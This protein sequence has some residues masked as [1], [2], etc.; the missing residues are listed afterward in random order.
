MNKKLSLTLI[1]LTSI[2]AIFSPIVV[3][4]FANATFDDVKISDNGAI[5]GVKKKKATEGF[6]DLFKKYRTVISGVSGI[7]ALSMLLF[8]IVQVFRLADSAQNPKQRAQAM[9]G[10]IWIGI[11]TALAGSVSLFTGLFYGMLK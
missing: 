3:N 6:N 7:V 11:A 9:S 4:Q 1:I 8:F 2:F 10:L 5:S